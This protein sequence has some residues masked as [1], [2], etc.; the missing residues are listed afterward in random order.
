MYVVTFDPRCQ[1]TSGGHDGACAMGEAA[2]LRGM[3][4][5]VGAAYLTPTLTP[6]LNL[7]LTLLLDPDP[8]RSYSL[9]PDQVGAALHRSAALVRRSRPRVHVP[10]HYCTTTTTTA[11]AAATTTTTTT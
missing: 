7:T 11:A 3:R 9:N 2:E 5:P 4:K 1:P 10:G 6:T 8:D